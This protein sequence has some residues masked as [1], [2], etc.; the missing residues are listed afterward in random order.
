MARLNII[1]RW[2][3]SNKFHIIS[4]FLIAYT[5][6]I[7]KMTRLNIIDIRDDKD[8]TNFTLFQNLITKIYNKILNYF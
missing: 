4:K 2:E 6:L 8:P 7:K 1:E 3:R 5:D